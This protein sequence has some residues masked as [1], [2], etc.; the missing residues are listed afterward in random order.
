[1]KERM[2]EKL[3]MKAEEI[4]NFFL[5]AKEKEI[6]FWRS[7]DWWI[8]CPEK[9]KKKIV[10]T[11]ENWEEKLE[12]IKT[13]G[14]RCSCP[15]E[16]KNVPFTGG[17][18]GVFSYDLGERLLCS[19]LSGPP[20]LRR[21]QR[22]CSE[23]RRG[24]IPLFEWRIYNTV[25][26]ANMR[27]EEIFFCGEE[28]KKDSFLT[29]PQS[30]PYSTTQ[31]F[32]AMGSRPSLRKR[33]PEGVLEKGF[34]LSSFHEKHPKEIWEKGFQKVKKDIYAGE[35]YQLNLT[36]QFVADF[37]GN[38][39]ALFQKLCEENPAPHAAF[40]GGEEY[41][42]L[43]ASPELFLRFDGDIVETHP[44]KG[45]RPRKSE[46]EA[47]EKEAQELLESDKEAAELLMITD[48]LRNDIK[49]TCTAGSIEVTHLRALQ[50]N[51]TVW[52]TFSQIIGKRKEEYSLFDTLF[53]CLP[54][55]SISGCPKKRACEI[56]AETEPHARGL[57]C[58][59]FGFV[60]EN[61]DGEFSILI[62]NLIHKKG[63]MHFQA[64]GGITAGSEQEQEFEEVMQKGKAFFSLSKNSSF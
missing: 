42:V 21:S 24:A 16:E 27:T 9:P 29:P 58:G 15:I 39:R 8:L 52:H 51:P 57:F 1:M 61:G 25:I 3:D 5:G 13:V 26:C 55:G 34:D 48:L 59:T 2:I 38:S 35:I 45:T 18:V 28:E 14:A 4:W 47:D 23:A 43:S 46:K 56:I 12:K 32:S 63:K 31:T 37:S 49:Q 20:S 17:G 19:P 54:G 41:E 33:E 6:A 53:S 60:N 30:S 22:G 64:G 11:S 62:R 7:G 50:K 36:R 10:G 40:F 44:I